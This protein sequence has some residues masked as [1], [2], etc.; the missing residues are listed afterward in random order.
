VVDLLKAKKLS[1]YYSDLLALDKISFTLKNGEII[2]VVGRRGS[3]K[4]ALVQAIGGMNPPSGGEILVDGKTVQPTSIHR[5]RGMGIELVHQTSQLVEHLDVVQNIFL[6][7]EIEKFPVLG[8]P[9]F[10]TMAQM[11]KSMMADFE[12]PEELINTPVSDLTDEQRHLVVLMR[13]FSQPFRILLLDDIL[14]NLSYRRQVILVDLI[15]R[16]AQRGAGVIVCSN[17]LNHIFNITNRIIVLLDGK[18]VANLLT[19]DCTPRDI[20]ELSV[21]ASDPEQV[22]PVI[23]ALENYQ[24]AQQQTEELF[25]KQEAMHEILEASDQLNQQ[26]VERL[27]R[28]VMAVNHLNAALQ[29]AQ[30]RL[31]TEREGERKALSRDLHDSVIQD[32]LGLNYRLETLEEAGNSDMHYEFNE[33]RTEIRQVVTDLRQVCRDLRPPTIDNHGLSSAIPSFI[34]EWEERNEIHVV[35]QIDNKLRRLPEWIEL[36]IFRIVQEGLNNVGKHSGAKSVVLAVNEIPGGNIQIR[37]VDDGKGIDSIPDLASLP[38]QKNF[39]LV[40]ISERAALLDG[41]LNIQTSLGGGF[42]LEIE[43]PNP[44]PFPRGIDS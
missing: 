21:G 29:D 40:G 34:Q 15:R 39:G 22:T 25:M 44:D 23:W 24:K 19:S 32:L 20:V 7:H 16:H 41:K 8:I 43:I 31:M 37:I 18:V 10:D 27:Q 2:G 5:A 33:I 12:L 4:S 26:L 13:A 9:D 38:E 28:Q 6:G 42:L 3:G 11:T 30:R 35:A 1:K 14:P 36:S 17:N